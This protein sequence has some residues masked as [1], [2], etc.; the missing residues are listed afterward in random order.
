MAIEG[1][2]TT[3]KNVKKE[4]AT[5]TV[6]LGENDLPH[7]YYRHRNNIS[8]RKTREKSKQKIKMTKEK[9]IRLRQENKD[10][11]SEMTVLNKEMV[12]LKELFHNLISR[13]NDKEFDDKDSVA[14]LILSWQ[15]TEKQ[16]CNA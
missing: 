16:K 9:I 8:V 14:V 3:M 4:M 1:I 6:M 7:K 13:T 11:S 12:Y 10:L 2:A 15:K 5:V